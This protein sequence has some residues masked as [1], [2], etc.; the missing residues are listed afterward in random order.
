MAISNYLFTLQMLSYGEGGRYQEQLYELLIQFVWVQCE[1]LHG[2]I[3]RKI[4]SPISG[5]HCPLGGWQGALPHS[6]TKVVGMGHRAVRPPWGIGY[7]GLEPTRTS[8][9]V[10]VSLE[11]RC[12]SRQPATVKLRTFS[13]EHLE[14]TSERGE[15]VRRAATASASTSC[16]LV[17][18]DHGGHVNRACLPK[19]HHN[20]DLSPL[21]I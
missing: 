15:L 14:G 11:L 20:K 5:C 3:I 10:Q 4:W 9:V 13:P 8:D 2:D 7:M 18:H 19:G 21:Y 17:S 12:H 6:T 16:G 1:G